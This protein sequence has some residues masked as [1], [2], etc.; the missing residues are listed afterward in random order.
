MMAKP[1]VV[2]IREI[3]HVTEMDKKKLNTWEDIWTG[4]R[5]RN[6]ENKNISRNV[7]AI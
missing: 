2:Q 1:V 7:E 6:M 5:T 3:S 4:G